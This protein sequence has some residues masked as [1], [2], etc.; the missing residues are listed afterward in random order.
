MKKTLSTAFIVL[1]VVVLASLLRLFA[2][3]VFVPGVLS[4]AVSTPTYSP[5]HYSIPPFL[6]NPD[7]DKILKQS[8]D[9][10]N[11]LMKDYNK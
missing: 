6:R 8:Q 3:S 7:P 9:E 2:V 10:V 11:D 1:V 4:P 5:I